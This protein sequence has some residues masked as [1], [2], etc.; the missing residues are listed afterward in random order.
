LARIDQ[1]I[2]YVSQLPQRQQKFLEKYK[3]YLNS[4]KEC[5]EAN[6]RVI[7]KMLANVD[8]LF[9]NSRNQSIIEPKDIE[10]VHDPDSDKVHITIKQIVR[11]W[12]DLG[13]SERDQCYKPIIAEVL[14]HF[15]VANMQKNQF[16]IVS[17]KK[18]KMTLKVT[19]FPLL[20]CAWRWTW[21][22]C[23]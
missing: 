12:T 18:Q 13:A 14:N 8:Q 4:T 3:R 1:R 21:S 10:Q 20:A 19:Q 17:K 2:C 11:D 22:T 6:N 9:I 7:D 16:K 5:V 23:L 15:D